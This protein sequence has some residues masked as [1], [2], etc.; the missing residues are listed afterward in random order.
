MALKSAHL[1][2]GI[3]FHRKVICDKAVV[4]QASNRGTRP[5]PQMKKVLARQHLKKSDIF[6]LASP[7]GCD[8]RQKLNW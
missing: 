3:S 1:L 5:R 7:D 2:A 4:I 6:V 8:P